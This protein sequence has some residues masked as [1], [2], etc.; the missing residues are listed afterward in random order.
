MFLK[1]LFYFIVF[2]KKSHIIF[3]AF[4]KHLTNQ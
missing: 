2:T 1:V 4:S 3:I